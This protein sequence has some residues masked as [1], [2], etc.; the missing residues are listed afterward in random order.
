MRL[1]SCVCRIPAAVDNLPADLLV[2]NVLRRFQSRDVGRAVVTAIKIQV[3]AMR[4]GNIVIKFVPEIPLVRQ[5]MSGTGISV[6]RLI[7]FLVAANNVPIEWH[8][9]IT[10]AQGV[11]RRH[12]PSLFMNK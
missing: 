5:T 6:Y 3:M 9:R 1:A 11:C 2:P 4:A 7:H 12:A 10:H 8:Q